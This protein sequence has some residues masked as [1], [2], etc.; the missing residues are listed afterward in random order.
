LELPAGNGSPPAILTAE[1]R[2]RLL[3]RSTVKEITRVLTVRGTVPEADQD[4]MTFELQLISGGKIIGPMPDEHRDTIIDAFN[5]FKDELQMIVNGVGRYDRQ[6]RLSSLHSIDQIT[7][8]D[9]LDVPSRLDELRNMQDGWLDG[10]GIA[11]SHTGLDWLTDNF[12]R[13]FP[14]DLP[15]PYIYPTPEGA[16]EAE[17]SLGSHSVIVEFNIETHMGEWLKYT[18]SSDLDDE[19]RTLDLDQ[20]ED[21]YA[22]TNSIRG[23]HEYRNG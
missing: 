2:Q 3:Q 14:D 9:A 15:L 18:Q 23:L 1:V 4:R 10:S 19:E 6:G 13:Y 11:P 22:I 17:W 12:G 7:L 21:W 20:A 16:I 5:G 8:V